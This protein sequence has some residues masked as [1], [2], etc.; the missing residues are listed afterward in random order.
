MAR[1]PGVAG[2]LLAAALLTAQPK[3]VTNGAGMEFMLVPA[4]GFTMGRWAPTCAPVGFQDNV[5]EAQHAECVKMAAAAARPGFR[6][7]IPRP[8]YLGRF[9]VTQAQFRKV[10]GTSPSY[11]TAER[12]GEPT[13]NNP[14]EG[15][16]WEDA[17]AFVRKLN[18]MEKTKGYRLPTE[19][20][21][22]YAARAGIDDDLQ[23]AKRA[24]VAWF[25]SNASYTTHP[26]GTKQANAWGLHDMLG[27]VWEWVEDWYNE[28]VQPDGP[29]GP[30]SG[31]VHVLRGG[32]FNSHE[33][34]VRV[35]V[36]AGCPGSVIN[37]GFRVLRETR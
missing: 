25:M 15:V 24:D 30:R 22:E 31:Q 32:A 2:F 13:D 19:A 18:A 1:P 16:R 11:F 6:V 12:T 17:Q 9:E 35:S 8:F 28:R 26:V 23:G 3:T 37:T 29:K 21:W 10:M 20:E 4:G 36:H 5:T 14:V 27:N 34:N 7:A 33:K